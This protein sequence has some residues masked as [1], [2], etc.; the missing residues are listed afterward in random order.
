MADLPETS[1]PSPG[2][3]RAAYQQAA[4]EGA[5]AVL[6]LT[7]SSKVSGTFGSAVAAADGL[8]RRARARPRHPFA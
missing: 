4:D 7:I 8:R 6:C 1:Q 2:A 3:F 5:D